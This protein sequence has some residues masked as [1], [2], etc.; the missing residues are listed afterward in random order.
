[1]EIKAA[2]FLK[3]TYVQ[4]HSTQHKFDVAA[5]L[6]AKVQHVNGWVNSGA[7]LRALRIYP[8]IGDLITVDLDLDAEEEDADRIEVSGGE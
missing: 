5:A 7:L 6:L 3:T 4:A 1:M 8:E 2:H